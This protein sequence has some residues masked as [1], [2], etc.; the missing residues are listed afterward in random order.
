MVFLSSVPILSFFF[1]C[2]FFCSK[3]LPHSSFVV[4]LRQLQKVLQCTPYLVVDWTPLGKGPEASP[5]NLDEVL[6]SQPLPRVASALKRCFWNR[7]L[8]HTRKTP[9]SC[10]CVSVRD[11]SELQCAYRL[12]VIVTEL[13][14]NAFLLMGRSTV[15]M[16][17]LEEMRNTL[18]VVVFSA[19]TAA[20]T[21]WFKVPPGTVGWRVAARFVTDHADGP[22]ILQPTTLHRHRQGGTRELMQKDGASLLSDT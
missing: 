18:C 5:M 12:F 4:T 10:C 7:F 20:R 16:W 11:N 6:S 15:N 2:L 8:S 19:N 1:I 21:Q 17:S 3:V 9:V 22:Q 14:G 13:R